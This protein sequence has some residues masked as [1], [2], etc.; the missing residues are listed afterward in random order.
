MSSISSNSTTLSIREAN[1]E[2]PS[3]LRPC[4]QKCCPLE[5]VLD[6]DSEFGDT[7]CKHS[8]FT[9]LPKFEDEMMYEENITVRP[10]II[11]LKDF[12]SK[13][14]RCENHSVYFHEHSADDLQT[15]GNIELFR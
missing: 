6:F 9:W 7:S 12:K 10:Y 15:D 1:C 13:G 11:Y 2:D 3:N 14:N 4:I 5:Q 8:N